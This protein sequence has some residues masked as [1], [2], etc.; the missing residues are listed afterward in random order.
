MLKTPVT[1]DV[2]ERLKSAIGVAAVLDDDAD[3]A[4]YLVDERRLFSGKASA[5]L[6]PAS[7]EAV[8]KI[9][10]ICAESNI[11]IVPQGGNTGL[12]GGSVP[13]HS[14]RQVLLSLSRMNRIRDLD[15]VNYTLTAEAGCVL[16]EIQRA[17]READRLFPLSL[18]AEGSCQIGGNLSTNAGGISV[19]RYGNARELVLGLEVVLP[20][21]KIW[22]GLRRLRKDNTGYDLKQIFLGAEGTLGIIT[23]AVLKLFPSPRETCTAMI[24]FRD[25]AAATELMARLREASGETVTSFEYIHRQCMD[26]VIRYM[27]GHVDP[28]DHRYEHYALVELSASRSGAGLDQILE[29]VCVRGFESGTLLDAVVAS[30]ESQRQL[31][32][33]IRESIP[34]AQKHAGVCIKHDVSVPVSKVPEFLERGTKLLTDAYHEAQ[35][36]AFGH[37]GDGNIHFNLQQ[38]EGEDSNAFMKE[39]PRITKAVHDLA[40]EFEGSFSAEHGIGVLKRKDLYGYKSEVEIEMMKSLKGALDPKGIMNPGKVI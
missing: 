36:I 31:L 28:F 33:A 34:E 22:N 10:S 35:V 30:S 14:G 17:A 15:P 38:P 40:I 16:E 26:L 8:A 29:S 39:A 37:M 18:A 25:T 24:A 20:N 21:G 13:D 3:M 9:V 6:R 2:I 23:A 11:G 4:D 5:V 1:S 12:C 32:W 19:L 7:T 27:H